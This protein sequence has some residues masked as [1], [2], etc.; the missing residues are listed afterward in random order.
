MIEKF[1]RLALY[2]W[3]IDTSASASALEATRI[4]GNDAAA[5]RRIDFK[6]GR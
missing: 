1:S 6:D 2:S 5:L 3:T 4:A